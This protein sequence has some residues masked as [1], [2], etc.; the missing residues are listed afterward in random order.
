MYYNQLVGGLKGAHGNYETDYY[1]ISH[2][3]ASEWLVRYLEKKNMQKVKVAATY[4]I[5]WFF[6]NK[7]GIETSVLRN[8]ERSQSDW[9]Y[10][11]IVNRYIS[12]LRLKSGSWPPENAIHVVYADSVPLCAVLERRTKDDFNGYTALNDGRNRDAVIFFEKALKRDDGDEM[13]FYNF[14][15]ALYNEKQYLKAD[16]VLKKAIRINPDF[17]PALM[18][19]GN[20]AKSNSRSVEAVMYYER[21]LKANRKYSEA[22]VG[23]AQLI[24]GSDVNRARSLLKTCLTLNPSYRPAI[25]A[26]ADTYRSSDPDVAR[27]YD[28]LANKIK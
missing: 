2:R 10:A 22:Y 25:I 3:E 5:D 9:D 16:S 27:K 1:Y 21:V 11:I 20:I 15:R 14:A 28:E 12:P 17:E 13:I 4:S 19:L 23:L 6:R 18:Y 7:Q 24:S 26:M 8:E